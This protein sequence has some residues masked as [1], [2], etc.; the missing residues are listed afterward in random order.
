MSV[1]QRIDLPDHLTRFTIDPGT[2]CWNW[3]GHL[4]R[5]GYGKVYHKGSSGRLAH[6]VVYEALVGPIPPRLVLDHLCR[7]HRCVNP[8]HLEDV[9]FA[10][11]VR[12]GLCSAATREMFNQMWAERTHCPRGHELAAVGVQARLRAGYT[13]RQCRA[14][15]LEDKR[16]NYQRAMDDPQRAARRREINRQAQARRRARLK[17]QAS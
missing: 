4:D 15:A 9:E 6:R 12:R 8:A 3:A 16:N 5:H 10:E 2:G 1:T 7:N 17:E 13:T 11:N 14:C